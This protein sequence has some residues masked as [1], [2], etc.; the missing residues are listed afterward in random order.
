MVYMEVEV[1]VV[2]VDVYVD[3]S[4]AGGKLSTA[5]SGLLSFLSA[6]YQLY[7]KNRQTPTKRGQN[8]SVISVNIRR[9]VIRFRFEF[10]KLVIK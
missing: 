5:C 6:G 9:H 1:E 7:Q 3:V 2:D 10:E 4:Q 8:E